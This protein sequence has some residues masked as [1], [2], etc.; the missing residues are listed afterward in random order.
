MHI[1]GKST[2]CVEKRGKRRVKAVSKWEKLHHF[3]IS[4]P[5]FPRLTHFR[6]HFFPPPPATTSERRRFAPALRPAATASFPVL[7]FIS[8]WFSYSRFLCC[9]S[10]TPLPM[11]G[12][13]LNRLGRTPRSNYRR[14][15]RSTPSFEIKRRTPKNAFFWP[16]RRTVFVMAQST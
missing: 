8:S 6:T 14:E 1:R 4:Q 9:Q 13:R 11:T 16:P 7:G 10:T 12:K 2:T 3:P 5:P 15:H